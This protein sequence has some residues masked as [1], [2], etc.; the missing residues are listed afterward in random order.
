MEV[1]N[2]I[3]QAIIKVLNYFDLFKFPLT[4]KEI[5]T[6]IT[7]SATSS[8]IKTNLDQLLKE[9]IIHQIEDCYLL[10]PKKEWVTRK[11]KGFSNAQKRM[12]R[13]HLVSNVIMSFPFVRMVAISGSLSKGYADEYSDID[14][15]I[16]TQSNNLWTCRTLLH[17]L[18]KL[19]FL[20]NLQH[21][22]CMNYFIADEHLE[23]EEKNYFTAIEL[24]TL[25]PVKGHAYY[26][27]LLEK[28]NWINRFLPNYQ[29]QKVDKEK[30]NPGGIKWL[31]ETLLRSP[32]LNAFFMRLT[33]TKWRKKWKNKGYN[34]EDYD[35]AFKTSLYVSK[36]HPTN[37]QKVILEQY[38]KKN[39]A[40]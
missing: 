1:E 27:K 36:N 5:R 15:F 37:N 17:L 16:V 6:Y 23:I 4:E 22:F 10:H 12:R 20:V 29:I 26:N 31:I 35:L 11:K 2:D 38:S 3:K 34:P 33:D 40:S 28:N 18:K 14:F 19:T 13:A 8:T 39:N 30:K 25:I 32:K 21:S 24:S 9:G 7:C